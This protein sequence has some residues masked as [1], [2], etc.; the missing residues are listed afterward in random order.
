MADMIGRTVPIPDNILD[1]IRGCVA[2][3][4]AAG[5]MAA[6]WQL[7]IDHRRWLLAEVDR[8]RGE[9]AAVDSTLSDAGIS[10]PTGARGVEDLAIQRDGHRARAEEAESELEF[11]RARATGH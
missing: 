6:R 1:H 2:S 8:L 10:Y 4:H 11:L 5:Y 7:A 3:E 9:L